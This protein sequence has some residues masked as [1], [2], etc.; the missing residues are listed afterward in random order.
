[1][2]ISLAD[3]GLYYKGL[4]VLIRLDRQIDDA[5]RT[6]MLRIGAVLGFER[7]FCEQ[8]IREILENTHIGD[9]PPQFSNPTVAES[10]LRDGI[11]VAMADRRIHETEREWLRTTAA[12]NGLDDDWLD[13][14]MTTIADGGEDARRLEAEH[15][16]VA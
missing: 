11:R 13:R 5:E 15:F 3:H 16:R 1:M 6:S 9:D 10:F 2:K 12:V 14:A 4:L 7:S 8:A